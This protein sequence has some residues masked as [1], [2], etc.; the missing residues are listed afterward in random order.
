MHHKVIYHLGITELC[1][2]SGHLSVGNFNAQM[3]ILF[4]AANVHKVIGHLNL[5]ALIRHGV[6]TVIVVIIPGFELT[7]R[8]VAI[9]VYPICIVH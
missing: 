5:C 8:L 2:I 1:L 6:I 7:I 3:A 4:R 9:R